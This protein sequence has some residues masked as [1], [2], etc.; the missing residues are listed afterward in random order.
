MIQEDFS[1]SKV[2]IYQ[3]TRIKMFIKR[4]IIF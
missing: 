2:Q 3:D 1:I 4:K